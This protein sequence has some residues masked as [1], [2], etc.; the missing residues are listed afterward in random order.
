MYVAFR[1]F[2]N[3]RFYY[4]VFTI[5]FLD[6]G[7]TLDQFALLNAVWAATIV[8]MEV[9]SG[10]LA[11]T[12]GRRN[13]LVFTGAIMI[14][15]IALLC[16]VPL[17]NSRLLF[18]VFLI[19]RVLSGTAE[20]AASG[21]DEALA[22]DTLKSEGD[23]ADWDKV[24]ERQMRYQSMAFILASSIGAAVYDPE[25]MQKV[26]D[27]LGLPL[28]FTQQMTLRFPMYLTLIMAV[29][30][31]VTTLRM[32]EVYT[33]EPGEEIGPFRQGQTSVLNA[34]KLTLKAGGWLLKTPFALIL[35]TS[36]MLFDHVIRMQLTLNSQY[37]R[38]I[39][40]PEAIFGLIGSG[41]ALLGL[42]IP[43]LARKMA[44]KRTPTFNLYALACMTVIG[45]YAMTW[46]I[47]YFGVAPMLLLYAVMLMAGFF[48]SHYLNEITDSDQ[49]ATVLSFKGLSYN[50]AYGLLGLMY[51][52]LLAILRRQSQSTGIKAA[53]LENS[54]FVDSI[55]WFPGYFIVL[56][57]LLWIFGAL[58]LR[59]RQAHK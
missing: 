41:M 31:L 53:D 2:F 52:G 10:A 15:E 3:G 19:N 36:G 50:L 39:K 38:L 20:A 56:F 12:V 49:R 45:L 51:S 22:Y 57:A 14:I 23:A 25:L 26:G 21:A 27:W 59:H 32:K 55:G 6:F 46:F 16:F 11:D 43:R 34:F 8:L 13:L 4:P 42:F 37:F 24:L 48:L 9:P 5:L 28:T 47:P 30:V 29:M 58:R 18:T 54:V 35:I 33:G 40:L 17:G 44:E 7:L 1:I